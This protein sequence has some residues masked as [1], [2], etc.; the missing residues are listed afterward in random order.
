MP[1]LVAMTYAALL[2]VAGILLSACVVAAWNFYRVKRL[3]RHAL[4]TKARTARDR[5]ARLFP[6]K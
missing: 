2:I 3:I 1:L 5:F 6:E 4:E